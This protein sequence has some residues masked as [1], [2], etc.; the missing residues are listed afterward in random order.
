MLTTDQKGT[1]AE[2]AIVAAAVKL[3]VDVYRP[4]GEGGRYDMIFD[5]EEQLT[6]IQCKWAS[7]YDDVLVVRCYSS[8]RTA[9]GRIINRC[10]TEEEVDYIAVYSVDVDNCYLIPPALWVGHRQVHLR[11]APSRNNQQA[12]IN[13]AKEYEF[14]ATL[15]R[16]GAVAQ[17]GERRA[18][19][20][21]ATG[22]SPVGSIDQ[23]HLLS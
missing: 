2:T 19:S 18:G 6:R 20:A 14:V 22:S 23:L 15:A 3:G 8:R 4:V 7:R 11:L 17:L 1:I 13:W 10:Y 21:K 12:G 5:L 9:G 16:L